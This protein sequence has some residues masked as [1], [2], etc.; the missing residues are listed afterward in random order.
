MSVKRKIGWGLC[1]RGW[2][3]GVIPNFLQRKEPQHQ[4][5]TTSFYTIFYNL[6]CGENGRIPVEEV[7]SRVN[8]TLLRRKFGVNSN[9][10]EKGSE[11][12]KKKS[13][14]DNSYSILLRIVIGCT[15]AQCSFI[16][17]LLAVIPISEYMAGG[18]QNSSNN[19]LLV[20]IIDLAVGIYACI[21]PIY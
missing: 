8:S 13:S 1:A 15:L 6:N 12:R 19:Y 18:T 17:T 16:I 5:E 14:L 7:P 3:T 11:I 4:T 20:L 9:S 2:F 21:L 10:S